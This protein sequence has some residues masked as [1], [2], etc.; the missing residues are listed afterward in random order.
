MPV[1]ALGAE[2]YLWESP[3]MAA[4]KRRLIGRRL[5]ELVG[6][7]H[8]KAHVF[9]DTVVLSGANL[10]RS[11]FE[12]RCDRYVVIEDARFAD[13]VHSTLQVMSRASWKVGADAQEE[14]PQVEPQRMK[15]ELERL[16]DNEQRGSSEVEAEG[17]VYVSPMVQLGVL[18]M[19]NDERLTERLLEAAEQEGGRLDMA[20]GYFNLTARM[21]ELVWRVARRLDV[22]V[23]VASPA[24]NAWA[25]S[26]GASRHVPAGYATLARRFVQ[27][28]SSDARLRLREWDRAGWS[29]H[30][31]G[32]WYWGPKVAATVIGS[33]N[34]GHRSHQLDLEF[35]AFMWSEAELFQAKLTADSARLEPFLRDW[36]PDMAD[37]PERRLPVAW[38]L[39]LP[40]I[41]KYM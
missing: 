25:G 37:Q 5:S 27:G 35:Q 19:R 38:K 6:V 39:V 40:L 22:A 10:S 18:G 32:L 2:L 13:A 15:A 30:A 3:K 11:Y 34:F 26:K 8:A 9:D 29:F 24:S 12:D 1:L 31:K 23:L 4:W 14:A 21:K 33:G 7:F 20:T 28:R 16:M 36:K 41:Q 17:A